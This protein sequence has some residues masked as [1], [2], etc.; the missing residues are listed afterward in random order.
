MWRGKPVVE[1]E[2]DLILSRSH[3]PTANPQDSQRGQTVAKR[4]QS[5]HGSFAGMPA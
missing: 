5:R 2:G 3:H 1:G 4:R